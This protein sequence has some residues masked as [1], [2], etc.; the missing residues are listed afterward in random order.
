MKST[1]ETTFWR[2]IKNIFKRP[3]VVPDPALTAAADKAET[4]ARIDALMAL[5]IK[6][7]STITMVGDDGV[8]GYNPPPR[9]RSDET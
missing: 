8:S 5:P 2:S 9:Q 3:A 1:T 6:E 7:R 4:T